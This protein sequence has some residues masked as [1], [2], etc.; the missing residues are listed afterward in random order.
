L[1]QLSIIDGV[2]SIGGMAFMSCNL[3]T[4]VTIPK[5]V[6]SIGNSPFRYCSSLTS[7][8]VTEGSTHY[9]SE[10][11]VLFNHD[12]TLLINYPVANDTT[13]YTI[14]DSVESVGDYAFYGGNKLTT[15]SIGENVRAIGERAFSYCEELLEI[16]I[17]DNVVA[18]GK[19]VLSS[20]SKI[21]YVT[22]GEKVQAIGE[23]A[24][25]YCTSLSAV[26]YQGSTVISTTGVFDYSFKNVCVPPDYGADYFCGIDVKTGPISDVCSSFQGMFDNCH[27]GALDENDNVVEKKKKKAQ[28]WEDKKDE[29]VEYSCVNDI[30]Y[31]SWSTCIGT[32]TE[33]L[34]CIEGK[35][36][37]ERTVVSVDAPIVE[38]EFYEGVINMSAVDTADILEILQVDFE[39]ET[40]GVT[41]AFEGDGQGYVTRIMIY[42]PDEETARFVMSA[43]ESLKEEGTS[44][45]LGKAGRIRLISWEKLISSSNRASITFTLFFI[46]TLVITMF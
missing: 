39:I 46:L 25:Y 44:G 31:L 42:V 22:I 34:M 1:T 24:F 3:L 6:I 28:E 32:E 27:K 30:G 45:I 10:N 26:L 20:C 9:V 12:K 29:C 15:I 35:C 19:D 43:L 4:Q 23:Y 41:I 13:S 40:N 8:D 2:K 14:P 5:S 21:V 18:L 7:I 33:P 36:T 17:P 38:V 11:G 16:V 37:G